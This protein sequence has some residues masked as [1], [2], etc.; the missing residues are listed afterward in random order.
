ML[1]QVTREGGFF[2]WR[3]PE[4]VCPAPRFRGAGQTCGQT[5]PV[6]ACGG[7][8]EFRSLV[9]NNNSFFISGP[10]VVEIFDDNRP[11]FR[12]FF[13]PP[14]WSRLLFPEPEMAEDALDH[15]GLIDQADDLHLMVAPGTTERVHFP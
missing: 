13:F 12:W 9:V 5:A 3:G 10:A 1:G 7:C 15:L 6:A 14:G 4:H 8:L 2:V 11:M